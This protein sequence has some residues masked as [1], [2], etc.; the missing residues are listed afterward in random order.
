MPNRKPTP[1]KGKRTTVKRVQSTEDLPPPPPIGHVTRHPEPD[2]D[3]WDGSGLTIRQKRFVDALVG[4]A[5]G[6]ATK[7]AEMAGYN[8]ENRLT[9]RVTAAEN[10]SKPN[11][12]TAIAHALAAQRL[13]PEWAK[14]QLA[15]MAS[16]SMAN[17]L[18]V[19]DD[20]EAKL[21][22]SKAAAMGALGQIKE[23]KEEGIKTGNDT[24]IIKRTIKLHD[25]VSA[26]GLLLK[27]HGL[28]GGDGNDDGD[29]R[30]IRVRVVNRR[31][32]KTDD[33]AAAD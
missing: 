1:P 30:E 7:A 23:L 28:V 6:N 10:L 12:Q 16:A 2:D 27:F 31:K 22:F 4:P 25:R 3:P 26:L 9:L 21:D 17:F 15:D 11:V 20:G 18:T 13:S 5:G 8:A 32:G 29:E 19:G 14:R 33:D 24:T